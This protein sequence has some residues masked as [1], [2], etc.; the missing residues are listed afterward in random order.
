MRFLRWIS[1][2]DSTSTKYE[3]FTVQAVDN[4]GNH[5]AARMTLNP[6]GHN[7]ARKDFATNVLGRQL[8]GQTTEEVPIMWR[9]D[10]SEDTTM[11]GPTQFLVASNFDPESD[12]VLGKQDCVKYGFLPAKRRWRLGKSKN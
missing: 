12:L 7:R 5:R 3:A 4:K 1:D 10:G 2:L 8:Q 11:L 6:S 9:I